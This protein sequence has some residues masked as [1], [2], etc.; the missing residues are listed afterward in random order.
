LGA[1]NE[2]TL[3]KIGDTRT[4]T[5]AGAGLAGSMLAVLLSRKGYCVELFERN[6]DP[7]GA[8][9]AGGRSIN[10]ALAERGR[11]ALRSAGLLEEVDR[12]TIPMRG[13]MVHGV[14]GQLELHPYGKDE[15]EVIWSTH[16]ARLNRSMLDA[17]AA[18]ERVKL[19]FDHALTGVDWNAQKLVFVDPN[20]HQRHQHGFEV[21]IG[22]DGAGS[23]VR[24]AIAQVEDIGLSEEMLDHGYRE[25]TIS[26]DPQGGYQLDPNALHIW[27]RGGFMLIALPNANGSFTATLFLAN[28]G[29]PGF[30]ELKDWPAQQA[31]MQAWFPD[32]M[33]LL[34]SLEADFRENPVGL[35]GTIRCRQWHYRGQAVLLGDAAHAIVP[36]HGQ[37]MNAAFEDCLEFMRCLEDNERDWQ[38]LFEEF[39]GRRIEHANAIA[40]MALENYKEMRETVLDPRFALRKALEHD[41]ERRHPRR[42]VPRYSLVMFHRLPYAEVYRRGQIQDRLL[43][44]LMRGVDQ[45]KAVDFKLA[46][47]LVAAELEELPA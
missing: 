12:Y 16:R 17:A 18:S 19:Y 23:P 25:L 8:D 43:D 35:L 4:I 13:R 24:G 47:E 6:P 32:A 44:L 1:E 37:G 2:D 22:A 9:A 33:P 42:F 7:R 29:H 3:V 5:I 30:A 31:F 15:S 14:D 36:F 26:P 10:L 28:D 40:D 45:L 39:Q 41:L 27:P 38:A 46:A 20:G 21:L 11:H 34:G